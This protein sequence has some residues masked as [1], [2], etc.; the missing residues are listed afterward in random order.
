M[1]ND[2][3]GIGFRSALYLFEKGALHNLIMHEL[4]RTGEFVIHTNQL[5]MV[6]F[7]EKTPTS[8]IFKCQNFLSIEEAITIIAEVEVGQDCLW[9]SVCMKKLE[10]VL[11]FESV[12]QKETSNGT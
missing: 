10:E 4:Q 7:L 5:G 6:I 12:L 8:I 11:S 2:C 3:S 1:S 9:N